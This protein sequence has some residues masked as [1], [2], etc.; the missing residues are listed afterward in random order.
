MIADKRPG[1]QRTGKSKTRN[2][3]SLPNKKR[4]QDSTNTNRITPNLKQ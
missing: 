4:D 3:E 2:H 1:T